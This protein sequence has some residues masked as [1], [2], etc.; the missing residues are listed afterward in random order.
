MLR[1]VKV[2]CSIFLLRTTYKF[3]DLV[4]QCKL[5][6]GSALVLYQLGNLDT[7]LS[8][9]LIGGTCLTFVRN[10]VAASVSVSLKTDFK[11]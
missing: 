6:S 1:E 2:L 5:F 4:V 7:T 11:I 3:M 8:I 10:S 9:L